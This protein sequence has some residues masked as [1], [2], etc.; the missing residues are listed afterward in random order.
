MDSNGFW[1]EVPSCAGKEL[2][3]TTTTTSTFGDE[4]R[5]RVGEG[6]A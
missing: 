3:A 1:N 2:V 4:S 5:L 6:K